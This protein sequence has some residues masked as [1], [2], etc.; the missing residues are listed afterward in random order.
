MKRVLLFV[1]IF[2]ANSTLACNKNFQ[3]NL[4]KTN[5]INK[6]YLS[7]DLNSYKY[8]SKKN[9]YI[10]DVMEELDP[11]GD[12]GNINCPYEN[13]YITHLIYSTKYIPK[14]KY[15]K[16][17]YKGFMCAT[18]EYK[19]EN[20]KPVELYY[21]YTGVFYDNNPHINLHIDMAYFNNL[22]KEINS[23][24]EYKYFGVIQNIKNLF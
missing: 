24:D 10:V 3:N 15:F 1:F 19:Y 21:N 6:G 17:K 18:G 16:V 14:K 5:F 7:Y 2:L 4:N 13:G 12:M 22:K 20:S 23:P 11:G 8:N 9:L